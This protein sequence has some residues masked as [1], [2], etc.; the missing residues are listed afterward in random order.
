[1]A[2]CRFHQ[3]RGQHKKGTAELI[4]QVQTHILIF[5]NYSPLSS[6]PQGSCMHVPERAA[7]TWSSLSQEAACSAPRRASS[8]PARSPETVSWACFFLQE[9]GFGQ[10]V[11]MAPI[12]VLVFIQN[13]PRKKTKTESGFICAAD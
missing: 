10:I 11:K 1:M 12:K 8:K 7:E 3:H 5:S 13:V 4:K 9:E 6:S 2:L